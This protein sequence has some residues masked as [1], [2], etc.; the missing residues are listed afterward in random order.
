MMPYD[1]L[2]T[3]VNQEDPMTGQFTRFRPLFR[4]RAVRWVLGAATLPVMLWACT[5]HPL[6]E[7]APAP[8]TQT[9][10]MYEINPG[11]MLDLIFM[12][13]NSDSMRQEQEN[14][15]A[16]FPRLIEKLQQIPG[17][18]PD[19]HLGVISSN[20]GAG[21]NKVAAACPPYGDYGRFQV[22][23]GCGLDAAANPWLEQDV[24]NRKQNFTGDLATTFS[25][26]AKLG[27][28]GCG[29]EHQLQSLRAAL[30]EVDPRNRGFLRP[31]A[32]L[33]IILMSDEDDCSAEPFATLF[34]EPIPDNQASSFLCSRRGHV[35]NGQEVPATDGF[36]APLSSCMPYERQQ[37]AALDAT[38][39][40]DEI[41]KKRLINVSELVT[42]IK[43]KKP[44]R[45]D[46]I[47]VSGIVGWPNSKEAAANANYKVGIVAK[48]NPPRME[49]DNVPICESANGRATAGVRL[50]SFIDAFGDNGS[51]YSICQD[52]FNDAVTAIG[53]T[54]A[55]KLANTCIN[56][57]LIDTDLAKD[58][59]QPECQVVDRVPK[60]N[61]Y[62][63]T[64][65]PACTTGKM[66]CWDLEPD[67]S[68][69]SGFHV[70]R[71]PADMPPP[72]G[73]LQ[74]IKCLTCTN[75]ANPTKVDPRCKR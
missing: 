1:R 20:F 28:D 60:G 54:L 70:V 12:I 42:F 56:S 43:A 41:R 50:K 59:L 68:C 49:L 2:Q 55:K 6:Q 40:Q 75:P 63:D 25:C 10:V 15:T 44:N 48:D 3:P 45:A 23:T 73:T 72:I 65:L 29:Y 57:P 22:K 64:P 53:D 46:R 19:I 31:E 36:S 9:D 38:P 67:N 66:P 58:G 52:N 21:P 14:L 7:P 74:G 61:D 32:Y 71:K 27:T 8:E 18:L 30:Y 26:L 17:G 33:G 13:D 51:I 5:S 39:D 34:D 62:Q 47:I 35:C 4:W 37:N 24:V 16:N 69:G 11:R